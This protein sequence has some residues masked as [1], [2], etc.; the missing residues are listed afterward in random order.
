MRETG[1]KEEEELRQCEEALKNW[2]EELRVWEGQLQKR[3][4]CTRYFHCMQSYFFMYH[5]SH[6]N[7]YFTETL[8]YNC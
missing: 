8:Y 2:K 4:K 6:S 3:K 5:N 7:I 1:L